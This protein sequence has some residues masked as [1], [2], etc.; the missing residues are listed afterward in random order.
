[1]ICVECMCYR[2]PLAEIG[3][4]YDPG[5]ARNRLAVCSGLHLA[6]LYVLNNQS[7]SVSNNRFK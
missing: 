1:M 6:E 2:Q 5:A 3:S 4:L 7:I